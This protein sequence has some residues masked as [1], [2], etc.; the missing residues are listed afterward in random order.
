MHCGLDHVTLS[1]GRDAQGGP[2]DRALRR[3][4]AALQGGR[5]GDARVPARAG[6]G[7]GRAAG[8]DRRRSGSRARSRPCSRTSG[9]RDAVEFLGFVPAAEKA[10]HLRAAWALVQPSPKEGWGLTVVEAGACGTAV[11]AADSPGLRDSV[12][13]DETGLLVPLRGRRRTGRCA[14]ARADRC[15]APRAAGGGRR[16][17]GGALHLARLRAALARRA[18]R[19]RAGRGRAGSGLVSGRGPWLIAG[20]I[21]L[22]AALMAFLFSRIPLDE[23]KHALVPRRWAPAGRG[24]RAPGAEQRARLVP[25]GPAAAGGGHP[26]PVLEGVR[27]LPRRPLL[28]QFPAGQHRRRHRAR[29]RRLALRREPRHR[30]LER[31][32][33]PPDRHRRARRAR[34]GDARCRRSTAS[35]SASSTWRWSRSSR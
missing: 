1:S 17:L 18:A 27:L 5:L 23:M 7:A 24:L 14:R 11:V 13:R 33:G 6:A 10:Q 32:H 3:P 28:Q 2:P 12:R 16:A 19:E 20:K 25:V 8:R 30:G 29:A 15:P 35:T 9:V 4:A 34:A 22:S 31:A 26:H 21:V